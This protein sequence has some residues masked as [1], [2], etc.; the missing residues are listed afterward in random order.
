MYEKF[1][2]LIRDLSQT[3]PSKQVKNQKVFYFNDQPVIFKAGQMND[4]HWVDIHIELTRFHI[5]NVASAIKVLKAN[6]EMGMSTPIPTWFGMNSSDNV[7]FINRLDWRHITAKILDEHV[8]RCV[9]Q[10]S[11]AL[12]SEGV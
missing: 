5:R 3:R 8:M 11:S 2:D 12:I 4:L 9:D 7:V 6:E 1:D 10:M